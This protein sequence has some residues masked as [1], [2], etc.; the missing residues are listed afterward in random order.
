MLFFSV[1]LYARCVD[2]VDRFDLEAW[3]HAQA[4]EQLNASVELDDP[5]TVLQTIVSVKQ[6]QTQVMD[7]L[8]AAQQQLEAEL[9]IS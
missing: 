4:D 6:Q 3:M 5:D 9:H 1:V 8:S 7:Q 2:R